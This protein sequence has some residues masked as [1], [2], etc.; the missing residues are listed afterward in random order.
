LPLT[1][2]NLLVVAIDRL[3]AGFLGPYGNT[4]VPTRA[5]NRLAGESWLAEFMLTTSSDLPSYY[6]SAWRGA[7]PL[8]Q[9]TAGPSLMEQWREDGRHALLVTDDADVAALPDAAHF[10]DRLVSPPSKPRQANST[11]ETHFAQLIDATIDRLATVPPKFALW[12]HAQGMAGAWDAPVELREHLRDEEDPPAAT[13]LE[14][15]ELRLP[16]HYDPDEL[17][18]ITQAYA[19]QV[20][21]I[22]EALEALFA[23]IDDAEFFQNT[24]VVLTSPRGYLLGQQR[25]VGAGYDALLEDLLHVPLLVRRPQQAQAAQREL[26]LL[27]PREL[28]ALLQSPA[29]WTPPPRERV[30]SIAPQE[31]SLRTPAWHW[32]E[33]TAAGGEDPVHELYAKPDDR[34]EVN[35]VAQ[36]CKLEEAELITAAATTAAALRAGTESDLEPLPDTLTDTLR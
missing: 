21:V 8:A 4:W 24:L 36:R 3:N 22:D 26:G 15:P 31:R 28:F 25:W 12:L 35:D 10:A 33:I 6:R 7:H 29:A 11:P 13:F 5:I 17:L 9:S 16:E 1:D 19:A 34:F 23:A 2:W 14:P 27:E 30:L 20:L 32:R 18:P